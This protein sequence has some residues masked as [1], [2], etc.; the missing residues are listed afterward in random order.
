MTDKVTLRRA[1]EG[2]YEV[3]RGGE[4]L[5]YIDRLLAGDGWSWD[6]HDFRYLREAKE[7]AAAAAGG[8]A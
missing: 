5:G 7:Y 3:R 1:Y 8:E 2:G 4:S 6:G